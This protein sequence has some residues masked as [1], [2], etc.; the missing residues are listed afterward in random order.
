[1]TPTF[2][3]VRLA[4]RIPARI[5]IDDVPDN[6]R[7][8]AGMTCTVVVAAPTREWAITSLFR[9]AFARPAPTGEIQ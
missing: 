3:W 4:Q 5:H 2:E 7:I 8:S 1:M 9:N 6:V